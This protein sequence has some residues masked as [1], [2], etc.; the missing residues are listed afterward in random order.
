MNYIS[1]VSGGGP[2][3]Q[4]VKDVILESNPL[5]E[6]F[7]NA[8][9]VRNNN[10]SRFVS[11][12][13]YLFP[14]RWAK[15]KFFLCYR[16]NTWKFNSIGVDNRRV[17]RSPTFSWRNPA[18]LPSTVWSEAFIY[19]INSVLELQTPWNVRK[20]GSVEINQSLRGELTTWAGSL[21][22]QWMRKF[23]IA[24]EL[25]LTQPD[26]FYYLNQSSCFGVEGTHDAHD[27]Q[28]T[29]QGE[30]HLCQIFCRVSI[31]LLHHRASGS[32]TW[33]APRFWT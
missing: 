16:G 26:Y 27:F 14:A 20:E 15:L 17:G 2:T 24:A 10:S 1:K 30:H 25:A 13:G 7:G 28:E 3:V 22:I 19:F 23:L 18:L 31:I 33:H 21:L 8:K 4:H 9:T 11:H 5:L 32:M 29:L 12:K 6:A